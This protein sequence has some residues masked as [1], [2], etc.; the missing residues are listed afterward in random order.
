MAEMEGL[1]VL[2]VLELN[3][4]LFVFWKSYLEKLQPNILRENSKNCA[5]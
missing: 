3:G 2:A 4:R 1:E 5:A